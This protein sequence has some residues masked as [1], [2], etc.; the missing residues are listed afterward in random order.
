[1]KSENIVSAAQSFRA[2]KGVE[3]SNEK[4]IYHNGQQCIVCDTGGVR[5]ASAATG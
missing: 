3:D 4:D 2:G 5:T 1:M